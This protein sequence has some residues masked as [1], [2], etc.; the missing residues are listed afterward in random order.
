M[1]LPLHTCV[2]VSSHIGVQAGGLFV[3]LEVE[4]FLTRLLTEAGVEEEDVKEYVYAGLEDFE[5]GA[6]KE[7]AAPDTTHFI[8]LHDTRFNKPHLGIRRG[9]MSLSG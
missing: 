2:Y 1:D 9:R 3:D 4:R 8:N 5:A 6:K 7:F